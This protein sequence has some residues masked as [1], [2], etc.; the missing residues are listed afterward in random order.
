MHRTKL[1][2]TET[3][4][5]V[6]RNCNS[7]VANAELMSILGQVTQPSLRPCGPRRGRQQTLGNAT[8]GLSGKSKRSKWV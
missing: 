6:H 4:T 2:I 5:G 8:I 7:D 3:S 1:G